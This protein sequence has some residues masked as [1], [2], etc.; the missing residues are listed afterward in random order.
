MARRDAV[1]SHIA[2]LLE[3]IQD[4]LEVNDIETV[5]DR[6]EEIEELREWLALEDFDRRG[7]NR[8]LKQYATHDEAWMWQ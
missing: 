6:G 3:D 8:R 1:P 4:D 2:N 7:V 5:R